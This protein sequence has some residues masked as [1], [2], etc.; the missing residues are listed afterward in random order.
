MKETS[1]Y[2]LKNAEMLTWTVTELG[3]ISANFITPQVLLIFANLL[4]SQRSA[5]KSLNSLYAFIWGDTNKERGEKE[6]FGYQICFG[7]RAAP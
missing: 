3:K 1:E 6:S 4:Y 2:Y 5:V 7:R